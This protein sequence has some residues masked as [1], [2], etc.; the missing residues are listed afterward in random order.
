MPR[1]ARARRQASS[2]RASMSLSANERVVNW[3]KAVSCRRRLSSMA[4]ARSMLREPARTW[5]VRK[6]W[7]PR[8]LVGHRGGFD[9]VLRRQFPRQRAAKPLREYKHDPEQRLTLRRGVM[10]SR[11]AVHGRS[12]AA[13]IETRSAFG[14]APGPILAR[15]FTA[16]CA[17][18]P[19]ELSPANAQVWCRARLLCA[20]HHTCALAGL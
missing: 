16:E 8:Q 20:R 3:A 13:A 15:R 7:A 12:A 9:F 19:G 14:S 4:S 10:A 18:P 11:R 6:R 2:M 17:R 1:P 5:P